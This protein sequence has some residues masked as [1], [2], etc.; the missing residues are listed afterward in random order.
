MAIQVTDFSGISLSSEPV[1]V[2]TR[3][4]GISLSSEPIKV[5]TDFSGI[6]LTALNNLIINIVDSDT[7]LPL[8]ANIEIVNN[9]DNNN[10]YS[11]GISGFEAS[12][13][14]YY[15]NVLSNVT[16][17]ISKNGY[18]TQIINLNNLDPNNL[19]IQEMQLSLIV[20][21]IPVLSCST[22]F[23]NE[24]GATTT[25]PLI[26]GYV[27]VIFSGST[28]FDINDYSVLFEAI[29]VGSLKTN[30]IILNNELI[31]STTSSYTYKVDVVQE[32]GD[33]CYLSNIIK[34]QC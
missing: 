11:N 3:F 10:I 30:S 14:S 19:Y 23:K 24:F 32:V 12:T 15:I 1:K 7:L 33:Y 34:K 31:D 20:V 27:E 17:T 29:P 16:I 13:H 2:V 21:G 18:A 8:D 6:S 25:R 4:S 26:N 9:T 28:D 5:V 22:T